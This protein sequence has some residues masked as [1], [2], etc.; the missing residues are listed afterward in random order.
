MPH[1][2]NRNK[3]LMLIFLIASLFV[4][5]LFMPHRMAQVHLPAERVFIVY[6]FPVT[7]TMLAS[8]L[9]MLI[10]VGLSFAVTRNMRIVPSGLQNLVEFVVETMLNLVESVAGPENGRRFFP[11]VATI[12]LFIITSNWLGL[13][14]GFGTIGF[15][16]VGERDQAT[17]VPLLRSANTDLNMTLA[18]AIVSVAATQYFGIRMVGFFRYT[19]RFINFGGRGIMDRVVNAFV[20]LLELVSELAKLV[21]FSFRLFGNIFA[22]EVLLA[23]MVFLIPLVAS[24]PFMALELFV[25]FIQAFIFAVLTLVFLTIATA[26]HEGAGGG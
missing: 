3:K 11:L 21:S 13:F 20:G 22:G 1:V 23:V 15:W 16:E 10:L 14:P 8:W 12:F 9:S 19:S 17:F 7:N 24:L 2:S 18:L 25:G 4:G 5:G 26:Q 6:G